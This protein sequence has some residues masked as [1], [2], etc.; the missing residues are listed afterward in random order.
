LIPPAVRSSSSNRLLT[1]KRLEFSVAPKLTSSGTDVDVD[2]AELFGIGNPPWADC[3]TPAEAV[4]SI[5]P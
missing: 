2:V 4:T 3:S 5:L 1:E